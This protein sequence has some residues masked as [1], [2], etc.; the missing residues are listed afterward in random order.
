MKVLTP[1]SVADVFVEVS[2]E[3]GRVPSP[4]TK[5]RRFGIPQR[6]MMGI[7]KSVIQNIGWTKYKLFPPIEITALFRELP[8]DPPTR[9]EVMTLLFQ[10]QKF[11][12]ER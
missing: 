7:G 8:L 2:P 12:L 1:V 4:S 10:F 9:L 6:Q 11:V 3:K 5:H